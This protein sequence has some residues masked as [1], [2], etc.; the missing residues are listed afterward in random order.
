MNSNSGMKDV[1]QEENMKNILTV[2]M[3]GILVG[4]ILLRKNI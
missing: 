1:A 4:K 3:K 2:K